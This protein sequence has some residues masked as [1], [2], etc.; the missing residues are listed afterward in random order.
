MADRVVHQVK[1][2]MP[3]PIAAAIHQGASLGGL[4]PGTLCRMLVRKWLRNAQVERPDEGHLLFPVR[5]HAAGDAT[6][7]VLFTEGEWSQLKG[8]SL[9][10]SSTIGSFVA[11]VLC[12]SVRS[13]ET[14]KR[15]VN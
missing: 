8:L 5:Q 7:K 13:R 1:I 10:D 12:I 6:M 3:R 2:H 9:A 14:E 4:R 11:Q 15:S